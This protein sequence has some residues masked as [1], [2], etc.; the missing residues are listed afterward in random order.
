MR[1]WVT[2]SGEGSENKGGNAGMI[3]VFARITLFTLLLLLM[4]QEQWFAQRKPVILGVEQGLSQ[5]AVRSIAQSQEGF[6]WIATW[7]GLDRFD[8][9]SFKNYG[10]IPDDPS[11]LS[12]NNLVNITVDNRDRPWVSAIDGKVDVLDPLTG[13]FT[14]LKDS[15]GEP[16]IAEW[17]NYPIRF[18][19]GHTVLLSSR[20]VMLINNSDLSCT[21]LPERGEIRNSEIVAAFIAT[22][23]FFCWISK[24]W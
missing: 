20:G 9:Y 2:A 23:S 14:H 17:N 15:K 19:N 6:L 7:G 16:L 8:G 1:S 22:I 18:D 11:S 21:L 12:N 13:K 10:Q 3:R 24:K 4:Q 5:A